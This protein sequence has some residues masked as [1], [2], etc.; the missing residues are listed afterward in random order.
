MR[1]IFRMGYEPC[2]GDCY[3]YDVTL[4]IDELN[5]ARREATIAKLL[6]MHAPMCGNEALRYGVDLD[7]EQK[8]FVGFF[9]HY[10]A[11]ETFLGPDMLGVV[12]AIA[13]SALAHFKSEQFKVEQGIAPG[14]GRGA[15]AYGSDESLV[16]FIN[17]SARSLPVAPA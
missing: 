1:K 16:D 7:E 2:K 15:C 12:D 4:P 17:R 13:E 8:L 10:G 6:E 3:E 5:T 14:L 9:Y 11:I